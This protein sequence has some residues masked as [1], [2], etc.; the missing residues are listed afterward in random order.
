MTTNYP[1]R[2]KDRF[3]EVQT[4]IVNDGR[5]LTMTARGVRFRGNDFDGLE[6]QDVS[7]P[8][9]I[10]SFTLLHG[11][12]CSCVIGADI[13]VAVSTPH[14]H[15]DGLLTFELELGEPLPMGR[16]DRERLKLWLTVNEQTYSSEGKT[17]WFEDEMLDLQG[18]LP[19]STF[20]KACIN[21]AFSDYSP[22]GHGL[23][24]GLAC[25]RGNKAGYRAVSSKKDLFGVWDTKT[26]FVQETHRC[27]EFEKRAPG[28]G[29]RG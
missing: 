1:T 27:P 7:D 11:S 25:F 10:S 15:V 16:L 9:Q 8:A 28:T 24:G 22:A 17:G 12:L 13:T 23:F 26:E 19:P 5:T 2:Y 18:K 3:G 20:M 21:C 6:P 29:Y 14:G 4:T